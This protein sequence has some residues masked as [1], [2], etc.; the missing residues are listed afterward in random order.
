MSRKKTAPARAEP[1]HKTYE[2]SLSLP[3]SADFP[4][5]AKP[6]KEPF[7]FAISPDGDYVAEGGNG[8]LRLY[9]IEP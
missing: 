9:R 8:I 5:P 1:T 4:Q 3:N 6:A 2:A 7:T